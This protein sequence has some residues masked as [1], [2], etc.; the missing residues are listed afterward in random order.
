MP[1]KSEDEERLVARP[2]GHPARVSVVADVTSEA[3]QKQERLI[4]RLRDRSW[5][6]LCSGDER[7]V[8]GIK[9]AASRA[10][11]C[12]S[13]DCSQKQQSVGNRRQQCEHLFQCRVG[14]D[15]TPL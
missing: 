11:R 13:M 1:T 8:G 14:P 6:S 2:E 12:T 10:R 15:L 3:C 7:K 9:N 5:G 4:N